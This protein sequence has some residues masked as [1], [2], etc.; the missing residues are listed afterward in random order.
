MLALLRRNSFSEFLVSIAPLKTKNSNKR[1]YVEYG[2]TRALLK[3]LCK[4]L[5]TIEP[6]AKTLS[7]EISARYRYAY[8]LATRQ[9]KDRTKSL[10]NRLRV[11]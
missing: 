5:S 7:Y 2:K 11:T 6:K 8:F 4:T 3:I 10:A 9:S 1:A